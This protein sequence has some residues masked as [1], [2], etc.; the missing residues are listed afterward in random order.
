MYLTKLIIMGRNLKKLGIIA[1][2]LIFLAVSVA[3]KFSLSKFFSLASPEGT[4]NTIILVSVFSGIAGLIDTLLGPGASSWWNPQLTGPEANPAIVAIVNSFIKLLMPLYILAIVLTGLYLL[5]ASSSPGGR[6]KAK[7]IF[8][9]LLFSIV[10]I[11]L[12][13]P[14]FQIILNVSAVL[15]SAIANVLNLNIFY[16]L[17]P[18]NLFLAGIITLFSSDPVLGL[19]AGSWMLLFNGLIIVI[20]AAR[21]VILLILAMLFPFTIFLWYL[22][23][24]LT[25][26]FGMNL[27]RWTYM[28]AFMSVIFVLVA[29]A[30]QIAISNYWNE[31]SVTKGLTGSV[32]GASAGGLGASAIGVTVFKKVIVDAAL[33]GKL[34]DFMYKKG[35]RYLGRA[36]VE[37]RVGMFATV[38]GA[39]G[40]VGFLLAEKNCGMTVFF[41]LAGTILMILAPL[42]MVGLAKWL[43]GAMVMYGL[44][45][46]N[47]PHGELFTLAGGVLAGMGPGSVI[48]Y[49]TQMAFRRGQPTVL[50]DTGASALGPKRG[51]TGN[52]R[53]NISSL[54]RSDQ[55]R[56]DSL[57][58]RAEA[59][60]TPNEIKRLEELSI[61]RAASEQNEFN[62]L[63]KKSGLATVPKD[64]Q[65][66]EKFTSGIGKEKLEKLKYHDK[67]LEGM[68]YGDVRRVSKGLEREEFGGEVVKKLKV[69]GGSLKKAGKWAGGGIKRGVGRGLGYIQGKI[70]K[71]P[72]TP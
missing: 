35:S 56:Y 46:W 28:W 57:Y 40:I 53:S 19:I 33:K 15:T 72:A 37:K 16:V 24:P 22:D 52:I 12:S 18:F 9:R 30:S 29:G 45:N 20:V 39:L 48:M 60:L 27:M 71:P 63:M 5:F 54:S 59:K 6:A 44:A 61:K 64:V 11:P 23:F 3:G 4:L 68:S 49:G 8:W 65:D 66:F 36:V 7:G 70:R 14:L 13:L 55:N 69:A 62:E 2:L 21:Y 43:G 67:E 47:R 41:S 42:M 58:S 1:L 25:R 34:G 10:L 38:T 31:C 26:A 50:L 51:V 32:S 17:L